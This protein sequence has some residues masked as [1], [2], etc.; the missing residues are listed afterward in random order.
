MF[1][2]KAI[3]KINLFLHITAVTANNYHLLESLAVFA[4]DI[5]DE[6]D[7]GES[8]SNNFRLSATEFS[9]ELEGENLIEKALNNFSPENKY[10]SC[11]LK[12]NIPVAAGLGGGS[13]DACAVIKHILNYPKLSDELIAKLT[14]LGADLP[15]CYEEKPKYVKGIGEILEPVI[16]LPEFYLVLVN[17]RKKLLTKEVFKNFDRNYFASPINFPK[18]F[19]NN[20]QEFI[21]FLAKTSNSLTTSAESLL[22]EISQI[23]N[24]LKN[25]KGCSL[26]RMSGSGPTCFGIFLNFDDAKN[27]QTN[28]INLL[29][30][31]W[32]KISGVKS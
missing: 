13:S 29:P 7:I 25:Q 8:A 2:L 5:F 19:N 24:L 12:K 20:F 3:A 23:L 10:F 26:S 18:N 31:Y 27:C 28:I 4:E 22:P 16:N 30:D 1:K 32:I 6:I 17:P 15:L 14:H 9:S 21:E 11:E